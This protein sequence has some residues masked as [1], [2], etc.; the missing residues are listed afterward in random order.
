MLQP[1]MTLKEVDKLLLGRLMKRE[2][3][4]NLEGNPRANLMAMYQ[5]G[6]DCFVVRDEEAWKAYRSLLQQ[7]KNAG[8]V[9]G[10]KKWEDSDGRDRGHERK[11]GGPVYLGIAMTSLH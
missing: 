2:K 5:N 11:R 4:M 1:R 3:R 9:Y 6:T 10:V 8:L 7:N